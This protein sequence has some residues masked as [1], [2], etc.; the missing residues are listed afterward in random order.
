MILEKCSDRFANEL[1]VTSILQQ[2]R[3]THGMIGNLL[4]KEQRELLKYSRDR[5]VNI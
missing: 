3:E 2:I 1:E 4:T 5:Y